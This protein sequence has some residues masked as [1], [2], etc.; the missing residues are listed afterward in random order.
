MRIEIEAESSRLSPDGCFVIV[1]VPVTI[2]GEAPSGG[3]SARLT[4]GSFLGRE[5]KLLLGADAQAILTFRIPEELFRP[6][7]RLSLMAFALENGTETILWSQRYETGWQAKVP[8]LQSLTD[9]LDGPLE[10]KL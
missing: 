4:V 3:I 9:H 8:F 7:E 6:H 2:V 5:T 10:E 1:R